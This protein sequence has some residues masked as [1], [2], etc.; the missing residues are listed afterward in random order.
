[1]GG[2]HAR[3]KFLCDHRV[4]IA[5]NILHERNEIIEK[6]A[7]EG[8]LEVDD[9]KLVVIEYHEVAGVQVAMDEPLWPGTGGRQERAPDG[10]ELLFGGFT[11]RAGDFIEE[12]LEL[13]AQ[14]RRI[15]RRQAAGRHAA[16]RAQSSAARP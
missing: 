15:E 13:G 8:I 9:H 4:Q 3:N 14:G 2:E 1:M 6:R 10:A 16:Q 7:L 5:S 11:K 12:E